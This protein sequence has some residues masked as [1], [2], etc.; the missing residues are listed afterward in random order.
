MNA[1][2]DATP[3]TPRT[4][5]EVEP[6]RPAMIETTLFDLIAALQEEADPSDDA[7]VIAAVADLVR[8]GRI[9]LRVPVVEN[10]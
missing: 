3:I 9:R 8:T 2:M 1:T 4:G 5:I 10:N 7:A 6:A